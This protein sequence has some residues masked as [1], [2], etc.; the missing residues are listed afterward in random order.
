[1]HG[2]HRVCWAFFFGWSQRMKQ[3]LNRFGV[4]GVWALSSPATLE[5]IHN[6]HSRESLSILSSFLYQVLEF[7]VCLTH[8]FLENKPAIHA[9]DQDKRE[10]NHR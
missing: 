3:G 4:I 8:S 2:I 5:E 10:P 6:C 1:M 7:V 9:V